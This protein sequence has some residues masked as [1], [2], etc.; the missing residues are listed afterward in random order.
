MASGA[1]FTVALPLRR[2]NVRETDE[3]RFEAK[4]LKAVHVLMV[5]EDTSTND[6]FRALLS[7]E[8]AQVTCTDSSEE[9]IRIVEDRAIDVVLSG[10]NLGGPER[11][12]FLAALRAKPENAHLPVIALSAVVQ[13]GGM[14]GAMQNGYSAYLTKPIVLDELMAAIARVRSP[15][16]E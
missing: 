13:R 10:L 15:R 14:Q 12:A 8:G 5:D 9:A 2:D 1:R 3:G 16:D 11:L 7:T 6:A 4:P